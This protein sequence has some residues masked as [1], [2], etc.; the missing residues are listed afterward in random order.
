MAENPM[1][2]EKAIVEAAER[3]VDAIRLFRT[4]KD[5]HSEYEAQYAFERLER[6]IDAAKADSTA[7]TRVLKERPSV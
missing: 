7:W 1:N 4:F 2:H 3:Y 6:A 5:R